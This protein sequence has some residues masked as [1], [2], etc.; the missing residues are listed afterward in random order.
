[1]K[2][3]LYRDSR[4]RV[5][6]QSES[7][8]IKY[9]NDK[10][11]VKGYQLFTIDKN[12]KNIEYGCRVKKPKFSY[13]NGLLE[14]LNTEYNCRSIVDIGCSSGLVSL[15]AYNNNFE[16]IVSLDHDPQYINTL[17][18]IKNDCNITKIHE[19]VYSFGDTNIGGVPLP[20]FD[21]VFCGA[22]IHWIFSLTADF[23]NF[24]SIISYLNSMTLKILVI[25]W[26]DP[27][28][29]AIRNLHHITKRK[30]DDDEPYNIQNFERAIKKVSTI[31]STKR[32][33]GSH[34]I[35]YTLLVNGASPSDTAP[36]SD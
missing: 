1:M 8:S 22:I 28:D 20:K 3:P 7:P 30:L 4:R 32:L 36:A 24:D 19:S 23:R 21:V 34:R 26:V 18:T 16:N 35:I 33:F 6:S 11:I 14:L 2:I 17:K 15:L 29:I 13:I 25:E 5:G 12:T 10:I 27:R 9:Y 31:I